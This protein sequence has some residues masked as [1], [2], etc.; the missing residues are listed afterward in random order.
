VYDAELHAIKRAIPRFVTRNEEYQSYTI[1]SDSQ[2]AIERC[3]DDK[4]GP[5][6]AMA[7]T[8]IDGSLRLAMN[9]CK[10]MLR[11]VSAHKHR[12]K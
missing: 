11:W 1:F 7:T 2:S 6:K 12:E 5:G 8:I 3:K 9:G 4:P 10:V